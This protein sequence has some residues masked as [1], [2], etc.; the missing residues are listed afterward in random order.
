MS[1]KPNILIILTDQHAAHLT[2]CYGNSIV[3]TPNLD[4]LAQEGS[5]FTRCYTA[6][7]VCVP[8]RMSFMT[9]RLPSSNQ[10]YNNIHILSSAIPCW[11]HV[12]GAAGYETCLAGRMHF[13]GPDQRHGFMR[14]VYGEWHARYPG[15]PEN[16]E[17]RF[18]FFPPSTQT[19]GRS[20]LEYSGTGTTSYQWF[21]NR[22]TEAACSYLSE[23]KGSKKPFALVA[24][25]L[26]PH[27]PYIAPP[28]L[29]SYY[30]KRINLPVSEANMPRGISK[31]RK[32]L[33]IADWAQYEAAAKTSLAAYY[34]LCEYMDRQTGILLSALE[35]NGLSENTLVIYTSDHGD[36]AAEHGLFWK[37]VFY[38]EAVKVPL[39]MRQPDVIP[40]GRVN[41]NLCSLLDIGPS[42]IEACEVIDK[43]PSLD[44]ISF[45][46]SACGKTKEPARKECFSEIVE[47][48]PRQNK[49]TLQVPACMLIEGNYK[50]W[51][52]YE[53]GQETDR[54]LFNLHD[55]P[56]EKN[57]LSG[58]GLDE[59][60]ILYDKI[61]QKWNPG[62]AARISS[63]LEQSFYLLA[64]FG[65]KAGFANEDLIENPPAVLEADFKKND[66]NDL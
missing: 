40:A 10:V 24:G 4:R 11:T 21:D 35:K 16:G 63:E 54:A 27:C 25:Y 66:E 38:E 33:G 50:I 46:P 51:V 22:V 26:L 36:M 43:R 49:S 14:R 29:F 62:Q 20:S 34:A 31:T 5:L 48:C 8:A 12:L 6:S 13:V 55:D 7:P 44:G 17:P 42:V 32:R 45:W 61:M 47:R 65:E 1:N 28:D 59:E 18:N 3:R 41:H 57:N 19:S 9:S 15:T 23:K 64:A 58:K 30:F 60:K 53:H 2:G 37:S 52:E 39:I 56:R